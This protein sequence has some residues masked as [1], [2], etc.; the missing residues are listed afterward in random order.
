[1]ANIVEEQLFQPL[2]SELQS[3]RFVI[4]ST[5]DSETGAPDVNAISW[6]YAKDERTLLF[7]VAKKSKIV[8]NIASSKHAV[9]T[10]IANE[11][12]YSISG[13]ATVKK[14]QMEGVSL[15]LSLIEL[16][17]KEVRDVMFYGSKIIA[18]PQYET[19]YDQKAA[20]KLDNQVYEALKEA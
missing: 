20:D 7:A 2:I 9:I 19:T 5:I 17:I 15:K 1:M 8:E 12:T 4:L 11:S 10:L 6:V 13:E 3:K 18:E 14:E 16:H